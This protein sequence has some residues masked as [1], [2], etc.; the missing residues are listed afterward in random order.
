M[1]QFPLRPAF[2]G[3]PN[4]KGAR[5]KPQNKKIELSVPYDSDIHRNDQKGDV[6]RYQKLISSVVNQHTS[7]GVGVIKDNALHITPIQEV[8]QIRP[9]FKE[10]EIR[11]EEVVEA[12]NDDSIV[13][14]SESQKLQHVQMR[15]NDS[16]KTAS[17]RQ[18]TFAQVQAREAAEKWHRVKV[19]QEG[20]SIILSIKVQYLKT[21]FHI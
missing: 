11:N 3:A 1:L 4:V 18:Q 17:A 14:N 21:C 6:T 20:I 19:H 15:R 8:L 9:S 13:D 12:F 16:S 2:A 10:L 7:L 5:I